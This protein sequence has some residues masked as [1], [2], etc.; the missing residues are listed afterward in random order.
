[1]PGHRPLNTPR[2]A[3]AVTDLAP[4]QRPPAE[5]REPSSSLLTPIRPNQRVRENPRVP[6]ALPLLDDRDYKELL[7]VL[8]ERIPV[9]A[10]GWTDF[11]ESDPGVTLIELFAFLLDSLL[12][13]DERQRQRRRQRRQR[14]A[15]LVVGMAGLGA[16][17]RTSQLLR[18]RDE[19]NPGEGST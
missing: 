1:M 16:L 17:S 15:L 11:N 4:V 6:L 14:L 10:P 19:R 7:D 13:R 8:V 3:A 2:R 9:D 18:S 12:W 5:C